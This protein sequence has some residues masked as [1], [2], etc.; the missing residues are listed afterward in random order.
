MDVR[1]T[2]LGTPSVQVGSTLHPSLPGKPVSF[3]LLVY[4]GVEGESTRDRL[5]AVFWP[6]SPQEKARH[7]LSQALY[8]LR[9]E[10]GERWIESVGNLVRTTS[11]LWTDAREFEAFIDQGRAGEA[12]D[13]YRGHFLAGVHLAQT[14]E[15]EDWV[16]HQRGHLSR[17][18]R[19]AVDA[20][21]QERRRQGDLDGALEKAWKWVRLDPLD[22][23]GQ[24]YLIE[25]LAETGSRTE[26]LSQFERYRA[27]LE[28][29]L[30]LT[31]LEETLELVEAIRGGHWETV[32][33]DPSGSAG[34]SQE[35][36]AAAGSDPSSGIVEEADPPGRAGPRKSTDPGGQWPAPPGSFNDVGETPGASSS[37]TDLRKRLESDLPPTFQILRSLGQ[38]TMSE[39]LLAREVPL[40]RLVA[41]K[42][43]LPHL[44][45]DERAR[46]RFEREAQA[47]ARINHPNVCNILTVGSLGDGTPYLVYPFVKGTTLKER[48]T[49]EGR[50]GTEEVRTIVRETASALSAA[51]RLGIIHRDLRPDN[52]LREEETG[53]H[54]LSDFG[55]AGVLEAGDRTDP[56][57]TMTGEVLGHPAYISPEQLEGLP[58]TG[59]SDVYSLGVMAHQLLTGH[60][61]QLRD[62][63]ADGGRG[64]AIPPDLE[65]LREYLGS[66]DPDL[67]DL[68]SRCLAT[69]PAS[70]PAAADIVR[71]CEDRALE[72]ERR[73]APPDLV[74]TPVGR[75][76]ELLMERR[77]LPIIGAYLAGSWVFIEATDQ[78]ENRGYV[79]E[80]AYQIALTTGLFG[81]L[82]TNVLAWF[83]GP[84]GRQR[85]TGLEAVILGALVVAWILAC[86]FIFTG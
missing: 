53:R 61:P 12:L 8:E 72:M 54:F 75:F 4:L 20:S 55:I 77:F 76:F 39:V 37:G 71:K 29:E 56:K 15:F 13:L 40:K 59:R 86:V 5:T 46:K 68:I 2:T 24:H 27:L 1:L 9:Q 6:Q 38:G 74:P 64:S 43:L 57:I 62:Q 73:N 60:P 78:L 85:M 58:L 45:R 26:A 49:A 22:D 30:S 17:R 33:R 18:H 16:S 82:A 7:A 35:D 34:T 28:A 81:F 52:V 25:L 66:T 84:R 41:I 10:L 42:V 44:Y 67:V 31:P 51:H 23:G 69:D 80:P 32:R 48:L 11:A 63:G 65:P 83:H 50:L 3:G 70:R 21:I 14:H 79:P 47:A 36:G 19:A